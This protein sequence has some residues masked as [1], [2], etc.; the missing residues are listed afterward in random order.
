MVSV[1]RLTALRRTQDYYID[2][3][4]RLSKQLDEYEE[5]SHQGESDLIVIEERLKEVW[6]GF[7]TNQHEIL[8]LDEEEHTR[9]LDIADQYDNVVMRVIRHISSVEQASTSIPT[10]CESGTGS[11][12]I[13]TPPSS[14]HRDRKFTPRPTSNTQGQRKQWKRKPT[15]SKEV[16]SPVT[17]PSDSVRHDQLVTAQMNIF[18]YKAQPIRSRALLDT[19]STMNFMTEKL[20]KSLGIKQGRCSIPIGARDTLKTT[21]KRYI[22]AT[23]T[24][25]EDTYKRTVTFLV[26]LT[27]VTLVSDKP[28]DR[29]IIQIPRSLQPADPRFHRPGPIDILLSAGP[30][31]ASLCVGQIINQSDDTD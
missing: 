15:T 24:S 22:T 5:S 1:D 8:K 3:L 25:M 29:S 28:V 18:N 27:I 10:K 13:S 14:L 23:I 7:E 2:Q 26:R 31:R 20:V 21:A 19:G 17:F 9:G 12:P 6:T 30:T 16:D 4:T 11:G